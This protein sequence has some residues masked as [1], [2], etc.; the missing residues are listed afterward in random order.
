MLTVKPIILDELYHFR[1][2]VSD[3]LRTI[4][5]KRE[6]SIQNLADDLDLGY[7]TYQGYETDDDNENTIQFRT[8]VRIADYYKMSVI[9]LLSYEDINNP[10]AREVVKK[11]EKLL[12]SLAANVQDTEGEMRIRKN[13]ESSLDAIVGQLKGRI[14]SLEEQLGK[15]SSGNQWKKKRAKKAK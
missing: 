1:V 3:I 12:E 10:P 7:T 4:R 11:Y 13:N 2:K 15:K 9:E 6:L 5:R 14:D 8:L